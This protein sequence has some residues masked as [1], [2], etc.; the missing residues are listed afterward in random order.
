MRACSMAC[1]VALDLDSMAHVTHAVDAGAGAAGAGGRPRAGR[2]VLSQLVLYSIVC[3]C[4]E[5]RRTP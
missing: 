1:M 4:S 2:A 5:T 3:W